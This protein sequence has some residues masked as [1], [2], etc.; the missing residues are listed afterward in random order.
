MI[1]KLRNPIERKTI[2]TTR[3]WLNLVSTMSSYRLLDH[4]EFF[5]SAKEPLLR[6]IMLMIATCNEGIPTRAA[7]MRIQGPDRLDGVQVMSFSKTEGFRGCGY[8]SKFVFDS[9]RP[10]N[11]VGLCGIGHELVDLRLR[12][13]AT[14]R[15]YPFSDFAVLGFADWTDPRE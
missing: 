13:S 4:P 5:F 6:T 8:L 11:H 7:L 10:S 12:L 1:G 14:S 3:R 15:Q 2:L 9:L